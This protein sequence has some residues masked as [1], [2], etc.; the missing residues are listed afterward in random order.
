VFAAAAASAFA[1]SALAAGAATPAPIS[2]ERRA[3]EAA[4]MRSV[5]PNQTANDMTSNVL[6]HVGERVAY[7]CRVEE[8]T[9]PPVVV[10]QC[11]ADSEPVDLYLKLPPGHWRVGD[12]IRVL[13]ILD[14]PASW[15]DI[16]GHTVYYP[17]VKA[18][19]A[20]RIR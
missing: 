6:A 20:D 5:K 14:T 15:S 13:G 11:G 19:F 3:Q 18:V 10:G 12:K 8:V 16:S 7:T 9:R 4:F 17:F 1:S 2:A